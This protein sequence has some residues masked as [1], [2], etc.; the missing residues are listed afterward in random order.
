MLETRLQSHPL[1]AAASAAGHAAPGAIV[2]SGGRAGVGATTL[3]VE[4]ASALTRE[5][6]RVV[7]IDANTAQPDVARRC[8]LAPRASIADVLSGGKNIHEV[9]QLGP[10]GMQILAGGPADQLAAALGARAIQRLLK[11]TRSLG[12]HA[13]WLVVDAGNQPSEMAAQWWSAAQHLLVVTSPDAAAVM[14]S[15]ALIKTLLAHRAISQAPALV[16]NQAANEAEARD[17]HRRIDQ[18]CRRFLGLAIEFAP[19]LP[20]DPGTK[21][22][23]MGAAVLTTEVLAPAVIELAHWLHE[24]HR[25]RTPAAA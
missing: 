18:S 5:A 16:V 25:L 13:D 8:N 7:L 20:L 23:V 9:L 6:L 12:P 4:L 2:V 21:A 15:Y 11:Q 14:D 24:R 3:A 22:M 17:V 10:A 19:W 1:D